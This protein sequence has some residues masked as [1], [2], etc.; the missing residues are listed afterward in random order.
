[1]LAS[2]FLLE[3]W[4]QV[5]PHKPQNKAKAKV[6]VQVVERWIMARL[7]AGSS[8]VC[9]NSIGRLPELLEDLNQRPFKNLDGCRRE[10]FERFDQ[11]LLRPLPLHPHG[12]AIFK[13]CKVN[14]DYHVGVNGGIDRVA[15]TLA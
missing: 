9:M 14:I 1:M 10:W 8:S 7:G 12:V 5:R 11:P 6:A 15:S 4:A 13:R 2:V 3:G